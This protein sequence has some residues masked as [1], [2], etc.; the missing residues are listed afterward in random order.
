MTAS[1]PDGRWKYAADLAAPGKRG[2]RAL[3]AKLEANASSCRGA[4]SGLSRSARPAGADTDAAA[5]AQTDTSS[6]QNAYADTAPHVHGRAG[7]DRAAIAKP[8]PK[9]QSRR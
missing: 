9:R 2:R 6:N 8:E 4:G 5:N 7:T 3:W 1:S